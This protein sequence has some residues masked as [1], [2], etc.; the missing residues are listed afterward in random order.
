MGPPATPIKDT[1]SA[2]EAENTEEGKEHLTKMK[3]TLNNVDELF[4]TTESGLEGMDP[5][6]KTQ[7]TDLFAMEKDV[8]VIANVLEG[9]IGRS[10]YKSSLSELKNRWEKLMNELP[11]VYTL[12]VEYGKMAEKFQNLCASCR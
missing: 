3:E 12:F 11:K 9:E 10:S 4:H 8:L 1:V 2:L 5:E 6:L 7:W